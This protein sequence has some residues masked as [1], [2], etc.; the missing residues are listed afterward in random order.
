MAA[1]VAAVSAGGHEAAMPEPWQVEEWQNDAIN[2]L[3]DSEKALLQRARM[4]I[5]AGFSPSSSE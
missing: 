2:S 5:D 3:N 4:K 1:L